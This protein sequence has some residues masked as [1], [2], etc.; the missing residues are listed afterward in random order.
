ME[1]LKEGSVA[2]AGNYPIY[3]LDANYHSCT[4]AAQKLLYLSSFIKRHKLL[5]AP[6]QN[7]LSDRN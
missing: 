2:L 1:I 7:F 6:N 5:F 4:I 3:Q